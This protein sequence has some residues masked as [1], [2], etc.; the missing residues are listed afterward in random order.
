MGWKGAYIVV[1]DPDHGAGAG[2]CH[3]VGSGA[4]NVLAVFFRLPI[5]RKPTQA[6]SEQWAHFRLAS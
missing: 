5:E 3:S 6:K 2:E 1:H 4:E